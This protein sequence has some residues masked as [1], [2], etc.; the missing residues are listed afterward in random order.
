MSEASPFPLPQF[1]YT[2]RE[3]VESS[4][5]L[6]KSPPPFA[7][8]GTGVIFGPPEA[9]GFHRADDFLRDHHLWTH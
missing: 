9:D 8:G 3:K 5:E 7:K 6:P 4:I 2:F 1:F